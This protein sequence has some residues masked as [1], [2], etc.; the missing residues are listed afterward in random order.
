MSGEQHEQ[1][2]QLHQFSTT[3]PFEQLKSVFT[4]LI[5]QNRQL[6]EQVNRLEKQSE[7]NYHTFINDLKETTEMC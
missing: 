3:F 4:E 6:K 1:Q 5:T 2:G 7:Q